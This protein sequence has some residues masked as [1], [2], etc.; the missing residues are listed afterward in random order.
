M[1]STHTY[2]TLDGIRGVAAISVFV[3]HFSDLFGFRPGSGYL[4][5]DLF[6][7]LSGFVL[8]YAYGKKLDQGSISWRHF[9]GLRLIRLYPLYLLSLALMILSLLITISLHL[10]TNWTFKDIFTST[11]FSIFF[12]PT[13]PLHSESVFPLNNPA[14]SLF[15]ELMVN[16]S[17]ALVAAK[18]TVGRLHAVILVSA[19]F[20][21]AAGL[22]SGSLDLG[23]NWSTILTGTPRVFFSFFVGIRLQN[24][25]IRLRLNSFLVLLLAGTILAIDPGPYRALYDLFCVLIVVPGL[26]AAGSNCEPPKILNSVCWIL[27]STSYA[28]YVLHVPATAGISGILKK[29]VGHMYAPESGILI[30]AALLAASLFLDKYF[31]NP[32]RKNLAA[33]L[34]RSLPI[35]S[36][37]SV[38]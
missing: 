11:V 8:S 12:L 21:V 28:L 10:P 19:V 35:A 4:A 14:W 29:M 20:L 34:R 30:L 2:R 31:D 24:L 38:R 3:W 6:F 9:M 7:C 18:L 16:L 22:V 15:F 27:G 37:R 33:I 17:Y 36:P 5:V 25:K 26:V 1:A 32:I 13:P 23:G